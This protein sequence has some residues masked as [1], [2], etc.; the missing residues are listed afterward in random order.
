MDIPGLDKER[1]LRNVIVILVEALKLYKARAYTTDKLLTALMGLPPTKRAEL[2]T[3]YVNSEATRLRLEFDDAAK[4]EAVHVEKALSGSG[5]F[6]DALR[7]YASRQHW[8]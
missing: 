8:K 5:E 1:D 4:K 6:V 7:L 2:T 3:A